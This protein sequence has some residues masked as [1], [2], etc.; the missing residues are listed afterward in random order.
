MDGVCHGRTGGTVTCG[1]PDHVA[2]IGRDRPCRAR[3]SAVV[4]CAFWAYWL[5]QTEWGVAS[6]T[7][8]TEKPA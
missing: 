4:Y 7:P 8:L 1:T 5:E 2:T 3:K 6:R